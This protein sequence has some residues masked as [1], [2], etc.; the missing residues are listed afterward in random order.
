L[1]TRSILVRM[2]PQAVLDRSWEDRARCKE[3]GVPTRVFYAK[4]PAK[5]RS[6]CAPCPVVEHCREYALIAPETHGVWGGLTPKERARIRRRRNLIGQV[7]LPKVRVRAVKPYRASP[8][9]SSS[10]AISCKA[11]VTAA[12]TLAPEDIKGEAVAPL[13]YGPL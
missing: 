2:S 8:I 12:V 10:L 3:L 11:G 7:G 6:V 9:G 5:A 1:S 13:F 4:R